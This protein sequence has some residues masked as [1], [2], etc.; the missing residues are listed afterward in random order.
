MT[1]ELQQYL[2]AVI[3]VV[4]IL[5]GIFCNNPKVSRFLSGKPDTTYS[6]VVRMIYI[7]GG[8]AMFWYSVKA[9]I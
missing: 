3:G 8:A 2:L 9:L 7:A 5:F 6:F 4:L 1:S